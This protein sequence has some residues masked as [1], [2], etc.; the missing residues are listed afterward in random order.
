MFGCMFFLVLFNFVNYV[1]LVCLFILIVTFTYSCCY[2][3]SVLCILFPCVFVAANKYIISYHISP[4]CNANFRCG[5]SLHLSKGDM[6]CK[7]E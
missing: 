5:D 3:Y 4:E 1:F 7:P 2:V 6:A